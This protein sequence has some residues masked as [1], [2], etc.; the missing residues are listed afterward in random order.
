MKEKRQQM[1]KLKN[2]NDVHKLLV[3]S[4]IDPIKETEK[5]RSQMKDRELQIESNRWKILAN[6]VF[7]NDPEGST[8][9]QL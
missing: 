5:F 6:R 2:R 4:D 1:L 3:L 7:L 8:N 9:A